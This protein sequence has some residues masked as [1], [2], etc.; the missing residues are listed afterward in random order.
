MGQR[1]STSSNDPIGDALGAV[2][3]GAAQAI[4]TAG[5]GCR[6]LKKP[7]AIIGL[8][9]ACAVCAAAYFFRRDLLALE[10][11]GGA[12]VPLPIRYLFLALLMLA[13]FL[14]LVALGSTQDRDAGRYEEIFKDI[15]FIGRDKKYP[16]FLGKREDGKTTILV[17]KSN[18]PLNDWKKEKESIETGLDCNIRRIQE[19]ANKRITELYTVPSDFKIPSML[20]WNDGYLQERDGMVVIGESDLDQLSFDLNRVPHVLAAGETGSGKSVILRM[21]LWQLI[22]QGCR[23]Y[24]IDFKGGVEFGKAYEQFGEVITDRQRALTVLKMLSN[25]NAARLKLFRD[26]EV[27]NLRE[28]NQKTG[29]HLCRIG[30][31]V[32]EIAEMLDK[33]GVAKEDRAIY[34]QLEGVISSLARL[35]RATGINLLFGVQRPDA[36]VLTGQ[37]KNNIPVR[38]SGRFADKAASEIVLG[39]TAACD[40]PDIKGRFLYKVGNEV[41]EFQSY[42]FDD[43]R[44]LH[45]VEVAPGDMLTQPGGTTATKA[46]TPPPASLD[47][48]PW[49]RE[50]AGSPNRAEGPDEPDG[51]DG[52]DDQED[53]DIPDDSTG[54]DFDFDD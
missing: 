8:V 13:P 44:D 34:E 40:L 42:Y 11:I 53:P 19:G 18:I 27:K 24:M 31:V 25:E 41:I 49:E 47:P 48:D 26:L 12:A 29:Q 36:N 15:G 2:L 21:I 51:P 37:I 3:R 50:G 22:N 16:Y 45:P 43:E 5:H 10:A 54:F 35:S 38:I 7:P 23:L 20:P 39:N 14:Y 52:P 6:R 4:R 46:A 33:K 17:F 30:V 28:Y 9:A 1:R 32:D